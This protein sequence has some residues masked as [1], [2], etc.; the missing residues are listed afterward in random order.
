MNLSAS[1][2]DILTLPTNIMAAI[3]LASGVLLFS[4]KSFLERL[5]IVDFRDENGFMIGLVF[6]LMVSIL[7]INLVFNSMKVIS[8]QKRNKEFY[9]N[10]KVK[11]L[12]LSDYQKAIIYGLFEEENRTYPLPLFDGAVQELE[13]LYIIKKATTTVLTANP[14]N[15]E[16]PYFL[17][18]WV[19]SE[20][21]KQPDI[22]ENLMLASKKYDYK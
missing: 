5:Y 14:N 8:D 21:K 3:S 7:I 2:K 22:L 1:I 18:P 20:I 15:P 4:P 11:I 10:A 17:Q 13:H 19:V 12:G 6:I 16:I 9:K